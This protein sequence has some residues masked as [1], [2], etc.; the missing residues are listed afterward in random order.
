M[1]VEELRGTPAAWT[2]G[3]GSWSEMAFLDW[4]QEWVDDLR[5]LPVIVSD[6]TFLWYLGGA[7][8]QDKGWAGTR[9]G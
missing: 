2:G 3:E 7:E 4:H 1:P 6:S 9:L 5:D 8:L